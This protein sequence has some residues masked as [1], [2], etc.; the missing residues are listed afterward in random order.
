MSLPPE[1][2]PNEPS[3]GPIWL[4]PTIIIAAIL[5]VAGLV[6]FSLTMRQAPATPDASAMVFPT[7]HPTLDPAL[8]PTAL[9]SAHGG[10][11]PD[12]PP[13][14]VISLA[15][16]RAYHEAGTAIFIDIRTSNEYAAGHILGAWTLS[17]AELQT[18][19]TGLP[20]ETRFIA[21][22]D[23]SRPESSQ[24][25]AQIFLDLGYPQVSALAGGFQDWAQAG[26]PVEP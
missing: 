14:E 24:R 17:D 19:M 13:V 2:T 20:T 7:G 10:V 23:A 5:V 8:D 12:G 21:Y 3:G 11:D 22:G 4:L 9:P 18:K 15:D 25:A 1:S 26:Y 16:A 6:T